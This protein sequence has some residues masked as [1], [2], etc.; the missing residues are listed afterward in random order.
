MSSVLQAIYA[1]NQAANAGATVEE[2]IQT[3]V[4]TYGGSTGGASVQQAAANYNAVNEQ[5][6]GSTP[7]KSDKGNNNQSGGFMDKLS[8]FFKTIGFSVEGGSKAQQNTGLVIGIIFL[9]GITAFGIS[10]AIGGGGSRKRRRR[11]R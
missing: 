7:P 1:A 5:L 2:A 10:R 8:G 3:G 11:R 9:I 4:D 6:Q